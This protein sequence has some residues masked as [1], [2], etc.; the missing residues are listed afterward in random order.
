LKKGMDYA[1]SVAAY[2]QAIALDP[3]EKKLAST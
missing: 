1:G 2:K 3:K